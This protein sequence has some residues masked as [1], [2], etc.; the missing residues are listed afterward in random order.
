MRI[1]TANL[2]SEVAALKA[3]A[4][5]RRADRPDLIRYRDDPVGYARDVLGVHLWD[6][7]AD[8]VRSLLE[9]P[10]RVSI[11]SGHGV[12]KTHAA[13]VVVNW[14]YDTR[15]PCWVITTAP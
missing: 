14:W 6:R 1:P 9:P 4:R 7:V 2:R 12:G 15:N 5:A 3:A 13:A 10:Y 8:A 11:D